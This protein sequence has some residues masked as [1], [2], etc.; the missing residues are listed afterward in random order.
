MFIKIT[1]TVNIE[2][3]TPLRVL[4]NAPLPIGPL[5][6][7]PENGAPWPVQ[8][9]GNALITL[10]P[11]LR[12]GETVQLRLETAPETPGVKL[13]ENSGALTLA[14]PDG[15]FGV[16]HFG[17][18]A[19]R[20]YLWPLRGP[21]GH[22]LTRA[23]PMENRDG[24]KHDHPHHRSLWTAFDE[25]NG[26]NN[27]HEEAPFGFTRHEAFAEQ[28]S[29]P[30][31]GGFT[32]QNR[33]EDPS[34]K[35]F[36]R[37]IR[38]LRVYNVGGAVRL[39]DYGITWQAEFGD[40]TFNDTKEAGV[41]AFRVATSMDGAR[42]GVI[43]NSEGGRGEKEC[44]GQRAAWCDYAGQV[45]EGENAAWQGIAV[46]SDPQNFDAPPRWHVRDYGLFAVNPFSNGSFTDGEKTPF[47]LQNG[48][49]VS[50][51][52]RVLLHGENPNLAAVWDALRNPP[53]AVVA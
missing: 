10:C 5:Q 33:W 21:E 20:P 34:G 14:L 9:D 28:S 26:V 50:F 38:R 4:V 43:S 2:Q 30:V 31:F 29:G 12:A 52:F 15:E 39:F 44:W 45:G 51:D 46:F 24:E 25:V 3:P 13:R 6:L 11:A 53:R 41:I 18:D 23:F 40:V 1:S 22:E 16:Y 36:L 7:V 32:A 35:P 19:P 17:N 49:S 37:E 42:G 48:V 8:T 47:T 27:W